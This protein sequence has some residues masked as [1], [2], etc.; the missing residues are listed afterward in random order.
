MIVWNENR[1][2]TQ[3]RGKHACAR[4]HGH[5]SAC[6]AQGAPKNLSSIY[7]VI[8][9][10]IFIFLNKFVFYFYERQ[11]KKIIIMGRD[12]MFKKICIFKKRK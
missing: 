12:E 1:C 10:G 5:P 4:S 8:A 7:F 11:F 3:A 2:S 6:H 9:F